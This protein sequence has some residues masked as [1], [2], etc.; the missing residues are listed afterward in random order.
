MWSQD[1]QGSERQLRSSAGIV[2]I[3]G[4][5][6]LSVNE[7]ICPACDKPMRKRM[8][9]YGVMVCHRCVSD[10]EFRRS[11]AFVIDYML[12][13]TIAAIVLAI[14]PIFESTPMTNDE[15]PGFMTGVLI[16]LL[17]DVVKLG[18]VIGLL[19]GLPNV[20]DDW[21][22]GMVLAGRCVVF[23]LVFAL[24]DGFYGRSP[25]KWLCGLVT[26]DQKSNEPIGFT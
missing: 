17:G 14:L 2:T 23:P 4:E 18:V 8:M 16:A 11:A 12:L 22:E 24:R 20:G 6:S 9:L 10:F 1:S 5:W 15:M 21:I 26:V 13:L 3:C 19:M 25:G 7:Q